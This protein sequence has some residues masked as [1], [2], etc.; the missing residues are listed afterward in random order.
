MFCIWE[1]GEMRHLEVLL[2]FSKAVTN[3]LFI[4]SGDVKW[5]I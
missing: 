5:Y 3:Y 1:D 4:A 2:S